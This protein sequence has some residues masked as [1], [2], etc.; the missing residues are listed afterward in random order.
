MRV[1]SL[2]AAVVAGVALVAL[3]GSTSHGITLRQPSP[4]VNAA[5]VLSQQCHCPDCTRACAQ[6][7]EPCPCQ[8][9]A[10][11]A[12]PGKIPTIM[13]EKIARPAVKTEPIVNLDATIHALSKLERNAEAIQEVKADQIAR[14]VDLTG[15]GLTITSPKT[16][17]PIMTLIATGDDEAFIFVAAGTE[18]KS[19]QRGICIGKQKAIP[20][21]YIAFYDHSNP[22]YKAHQFALMLDDNLRPVM[23]LT[24]LV[25]VNGKEQSQTRFIDLDAVAD[26]VDQAKAATLKKSQ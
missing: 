25:T 6:G 14:S 8:P 5:M 19:S 26:L 7:L 10:L 22:K 4:T 18:G 17:K 9:A 3:A 13:A 11:A 1:Y 15:S 23:Q 20:Q 24:K 21:P 2:L 12:M 16:D